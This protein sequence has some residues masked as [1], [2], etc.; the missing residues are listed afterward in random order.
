MDLLAHGC[1]DPECNQ[2]AGIF[3]RADIRS[4]QHTRYK[5]G[6]CDDEP[7]GYENQL[8]AARTTPRK[9]SMVDLTRPRKYEE[10]EIPSDN[11]HHTKPP[12]QPSE[13]ATTAAMHDRVVVNR[14]GR[15]IETPRSGADDQAARFQQFLRKLQRTARGSP[16]KDKE[17]I[18]GSS[19]RRMQDS[20]SSSTDTSGSVKRSLNPLAKEFAAISSK[21]RPVV[22][23]KRGS[24]TSMNIPLSILTQIM[25]QNDSVKES[26]DCSQPVLNK[27]IVDILRKL[28]IRNEGP[29][30]AMPPSMGVPPVSLPFGV[31]PLMVSPTI[32]SAFGLH[33]QAAMG[34]PPGLP[35]PTGQLGQAAMRPPP[36]LPYPAGQ[37]LPMMPV[38]GTTPALSQQQ[39]GAGGLPQG[40]TGLPLLPLG[41]NPIQAGFNQAGLYQGGFGHGG[42]PLATSFGPPPA[43]KPR[44]PDAMAQQQYEAYIEFRKA[45]DPQYALECKQ[46]Q[47]K[48]AA[49]SNTQPSSSSSKTV[50]KHGAWDSSADSTST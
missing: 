39:P 42:P 2:H 13:N 36:G 38:P 1:D 12:Q 19:Q 9:H 44:V 47:A 43:R 17:N 30:V 27:T 21:E 6:A 23:E 10:R 29:Q 33:G 8:G 41:Q 50:L 28:G 37:Q 31:P 45:N 40:I 7:L 4:I 22:V 26:G 35:Y 16:S 11:E 34:P 14:D 25:A 32:P 46:R 49:R 3:N 48:R 24:E 5:F 20:S 18:R 15:E